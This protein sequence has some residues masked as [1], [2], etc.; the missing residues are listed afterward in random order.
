VGNALAAN[1]MGKP[2]VRMARYGNDKLDRWGGV[3]LRSSAANIA[4]T[5][6]WLSQV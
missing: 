3:S 1:K 2:M 4:S 6:D 5:F